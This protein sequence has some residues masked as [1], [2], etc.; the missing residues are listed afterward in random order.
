[1]NNLLHPSG[2]SYE[3]L[4]KYVRDTWVEWASRQ[5]NPS[6]KH[7][8]TWAQIQITQPEQVEIDILIGKAVAD[9]VWQQQKS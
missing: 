6:P 1:M 8:E 4:G 9:L 2:I 5:E 7:L 3:I